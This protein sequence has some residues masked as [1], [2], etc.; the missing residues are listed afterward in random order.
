M[1]ET[2]HQQAFNEV[3]DISPLRPLHWKI[4]SLSA[5]GVFL[6]GFDLFIIGIALPLIVVQYHPSNN[7]VGL[8]AAAASLGAIV[9]ALAGGFLTDRWG[10]KPIYVLDMFC[11]MVFSL[12]SAFTHGLASLIAMRFF[13]GMSIGA[14]YPICASYVSEFMPAR[15]RGRMLISAFSFQALGMAAAATLGA[16]ILKFHPAVEDWRWM[17]G[18]PSVLALVVLWLRLGVPESARWHLEHGHYQKAVAIVAQVVP[19]KKAVLL[20]L[21]EKEAR[22]IEKIEERKLGYLDLFTAKFRRRTVLAVVPWFLM[23]IATYGIG[24]FT[25]FIL[26]ALIVGPTANPPG[27]VDDILKD[28]HATEGAAVI[29]L[30]LIVGFVLNILLVE[31]LGRIRL[32]VIGFAGM[33]AGMAVLALT[34]AQLN[35]HQTPSVALVFLGFILFNV[36]MNLGPNATTFLLPAELFPTKIRASGHGLAAGAAK[37]GAAVGLFF[38]PGFKSHYGIVATVLV[39]G[40]ICLIA[41]IVTI[42]TRIETTGRSLEE[43]HPGEVL[44]D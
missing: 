28:L 16:L 7:A 27:L 37:F 33:A 26:A 42:A 9:G 19:E 5:M 20:E 36:M 41:L 24:I 34:G 13:M 1:S 18:L 22:H 14:D 4:W 8:V 17:L 30:F 40:F 31:R 2:S 35:A 21:L 10:R 44:V 23:D 29:D 11:V 43:L 39:M 12:A 3:L 15:L 6:D 32:Q 25:P 38:L